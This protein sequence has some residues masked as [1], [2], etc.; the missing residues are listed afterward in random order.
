MKLHGKR[1]AKLKNNLEDIKRIIHDAKELGNQV[2]D[3]WS[4]EPLTRDISIAMRER[5]MIGYDGY[6]IID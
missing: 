1:E 4:R 2:E 5:E 3:F 6:A